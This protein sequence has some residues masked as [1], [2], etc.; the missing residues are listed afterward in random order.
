MS[1]SRSDTREDKSAEL[2]D[3]VI[4]GNKTLAKLDD[5]PIP[6]FDYN[7]Q[8]CTDAVSSIASTLKFAS[9][10]DV[11]EECEDQHGNLI[12]DIDSAHDDIDTWY[13]N[14]ITAYQ[15]LEAQNEHL[16]MCINDLIS[17][18]ADKVDQHDVKEFE[19][20]LIMK[21]LEGKK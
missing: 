5:T 18:A 20:F 9:S 14:I 15:E 3:F 11:C 13:G 19:Q 7:I 6:D 16:R 2:L 1:T 10:K 4:Y 17:F 21:N 12:D 8:R